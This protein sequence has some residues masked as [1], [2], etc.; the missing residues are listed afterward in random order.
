MSGW[1]GRV[2]ICCMVVVLFG[3]SGLSAESSRLESTAAIYTE[4]LAAKRDE[5]EQKLDELLKASKQHHLYLTDFQKLHLNIVEAELFTDLSR[6]DQADSLF[7]IIEKADLTQFSEFERKKIEILVRI[8]R[9]KYLRKKGQ[10]AQSME[11]LSECLR[12]ET[13]SDLD[14]EKIRVMGEA[15]YSSYQ[16][17]RL[18]DAETYYLAEINLSCRSPSFIEYRI[19]GNI[20]LALVLK[21]KGRYGEAIDR[22][23]SVLS[24]LK[25][26][27]YHNRKKESF[28]YGNLGVIYKYLGLY[29]KSISYFEMAR[30]AKLAH[31][32]KYENHLYLDQIASL[33]RL[34]GRH[35]VSIEKLLYFIQHENN[36]SRLFIAKKELALN[37]LATQEYQRALTEIDSAIEIRQK[38]HYMT[39]IAELYAIKGEIL[40][41]LQ[42]YPEAKKIFRQGYNLSLELQTPEFEWKNLVGLGRIVADSETIEN[43][44]PYYDQAIEIIESMRQDLSSKE[45]KISF[46]RDKIIVY[47]EYIKILTQAHQ[48]DPSGGYDQKALEVFERKQGRIFLEEMGKSGA[49]YFAGLPREILKKEEE[50]NVQLEKLQEKLTKERSNSRKQ[51]NYRRIQKLEGRIGEIE[52]DYDKHKKILKA[53]YPDYY[54]LK[55]P[56]PVILS[57]LQNDVL[58]PDE[59]MLIYCVMDDRT[60]LWVVGRSHFSLHTIDVKEDEITRFVLDYRYRF[61]CVDDIPP[62]EPES[63]HTAPRIEDITDLYALLIPAS[64]ENAVAGS[65]SL[66]II[67][68]RNLYLL[69][70]ETLKNG[71]GRYMIENCAISY[72]SSAS[73]LNILRDSR[74]RKEQSAPHPLLVF[75][76]PVYGTHK[77]EN[78]TSSVLCGLRSETYRNTLGGN[79]V[80][81]PETEE[82]ARMILEIFEAPDKTHPLQTG[83]HAAR[84]RVLKFNAKGILDN[85]RYL[86]FA[87]HGV[88][89]GEM[90][91]V[92]QPALVLSNPDPYTGESGF[93][94]M[95]DVFGLSM[96]AELVTLSACNTGRGDNVKGEGVMGLTRA[97]MYAGTPALTVT[98]WSVETNSIKELNIGFFTNLK[99]GTPRSQALQRIKIDMIRGQY[100][101]GWKHPYYWASVILFGDGA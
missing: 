30:N 4:I 45:S 87:C 23:T 61:L 66:Y 92:S 58:S 86:I 35:N 10:I 9:S 2:L 98:L 50:Y 70:F 42:S 77:I 59:K 85:Y 97:F 89:P 12:Q 99:S 88:I 33:E 36:E 6:F 51:I 13:F 38:T 37:Y 3:I 14:E 56:N 60:V 95:A 39:Y 41:H 69:P 72:L 65:R 52:K 1:V 53:D 54:A 71:Q 29:Q 93:L 57:D 28:I 79:F 21:T 73:L 20:G 47:D 48:K 78:E 44:I 84:S 94:T 16:L 80:S 67:P 22:F 26:R 76:N 40:Y 91:Q 8:A 55:Y 62:A 68:T 18:D 25:T 11:I 31:N 32:P 75:A 49:R 43:A 19:H 27:T 15:G 46:I 17:G 96:N 7:E 24:T 63:S 81:L 34:L 90:T 64:V 82:E 74:A 101:P 83:E 100:H 5:N